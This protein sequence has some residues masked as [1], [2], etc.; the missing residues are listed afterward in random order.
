MLCRFRNAWKNDWC[1]VRERMARLNVFLSTFSIHLRHNSVTFQSHSCGF[2][3]Y[4]HVFHTVFYFFKR[5]KNDGWHFFL[6]PSEF[7]D[8]LGTPKP[9]LEEGGVP[10]KCTCRSFIF[11]GFIPFSILLF[12]HVLDAFPPFSWIVK[13]IQSQLNRS[14][15]RT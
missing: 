9:S 14:E 7:R 2:L 12:F 6:Y 15:E 3:H 8:A 10:N 13:V 11:P 1:V 4:L 5:E